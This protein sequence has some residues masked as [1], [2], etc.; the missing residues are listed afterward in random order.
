MNGCVQLDLV[1]N[2]WILGVFSIINELL[3]I[4]WWFNWFME[5]KNLKQVLW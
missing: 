5:L 3:E 4:V 1:G 2:V